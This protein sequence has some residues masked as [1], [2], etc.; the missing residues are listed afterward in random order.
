MTE[1]VRPP[2]EHAHLRWHWLVGQNGL[3]LIAQWEPTTLTGGW[4]TFGGWSGAIAMWGNGIRY[5]G[6]CDPAAIVPDPEN[7]EMVE[8]VARALCTANSR[9]SGAPRWVDI[10]TRETWGICWHEN[11]ERARAAV[12]ALAKFGEAK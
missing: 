2:P 1:G 7:A 10:R 3:P 6:P 12:T 11:I 5:H 9:G 4:R 8:C